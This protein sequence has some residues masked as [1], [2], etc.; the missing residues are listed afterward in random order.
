MPVSVK[1]EAWVLHAVCCR[2]VIVTVSASWAKSPGAPLAAVFTV[3]ESTPMR[4]CVQVDEIERVRVELDGFVGEA[5]VSF[6]AE[7][8]AGEGVAFTCRG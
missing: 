1:T 4:H 8:S 7:G 3:E 5:F 2:W 6:G